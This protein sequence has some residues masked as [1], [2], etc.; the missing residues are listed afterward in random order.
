MSTTSWAK[1]LLCLAPAVLSAADDEHNCTI[2]DAA[3]PS[4]SITYVLC[5]QGLLLVTGDEG[6]TWATRKIADA[7]GL[8]A[9]SF[10][11]V[12]RGL[13]V[14]DGGAILATVDG[15][16]TWTRRTSGTT[17]NLSGIQMQGEEG[18]TVGFDGVILHTADGGGTWAAQK[19]GVTQSLE[20]LYFLDA[21]NGWAVGW[22][23]TILH[24]A[25]GGNTWK[26]VKATAAM[27]SLSSIHFTDAQNGFISGFAGQLLRTKDGGATWDPVKTPY[28]GWLT[29][30]TFDNSNRAWITTD[31]GL[32]LSTDGGSTWKMTNG[33]AQFFLNKLRRT[34]SAV[35]ALGPFGLMKQT[36]SGTEW[37][38]IVNPLANDSTI[39]GTT[40]ATTGAK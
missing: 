7:S 10:I 25:D 36:G 39:G 13:T 33:E 31:D 11:T 3:A 17:E 28:S 38:K 35:W 26:Q 5:E 18:W 40:A 6:A 1:L 34:P 37:K 24:T 4:S 8:S 15:G 27:W 9:M 12:N 2:R 20:A 22:S 16:K 19:S 23:G 21:K 32:L 29:S 30:V 14:G